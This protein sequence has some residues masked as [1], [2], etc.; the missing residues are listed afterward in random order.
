MASRHDGGDAHAE[1]AVP[2]SALGN[3][4]RPDE[5]HTRLAL[6][7]RR[8]RARRPRAERRDEPD[9][10][11]HHPPVRRTRRRVSEVQVPDESTARRGVRRRGARVIR[12]CRRGR[13][14][15]AA[16]TREARAIDRRGA[17]AVRPRRDARGS[18]R[19]AT[20]D[21]SHPGARR[22]VRRRGG[23]REKHARGRV[24]SGFKVEKKQQKH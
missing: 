23:E 13:A 8:P 6:H 7:E 22:G 24:T 1:L 4:V 17:R 2:V 5:S 19:R 21:A 9:A 16:G 18:P 20:R 14:P 3:V 10:G 12:G 11:H 15:R